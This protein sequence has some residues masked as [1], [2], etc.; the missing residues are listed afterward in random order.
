MQKEREEEYQNALIKMEDY[1]RT[2]HGPKLTEQIGDELRRWIR[3][4]YDRTERFPEMPSEESGGSRAMYSRQ[5]KVFNLYLF[6]NLL[7]AMYLLTVAMSCFGTNGS[8]LSK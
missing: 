7:L 4:Y 1:I 2:Q 6:L 3:E 5:G 8:I